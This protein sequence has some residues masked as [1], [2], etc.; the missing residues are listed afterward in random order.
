MN[1]FEQEL[2]KYRFQLQE[3][4]PE[5]F[6]EEGLIEEAKWLGPSIYDAD[7]ALVACSDPKELDRVRL[8]FTAKRFGCE[9]EPEW[10][11]EAIE[12]V[13][14]VQMT[15]VNRKYRAVFQ[16]L[17]AVRLGMYAQTPS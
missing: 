2:D 1:R 4:S 12:H 3:V 14:K 8:A 5:G 16:Y 17:V 11:D 9:Y 15:G 10:I 7:S 13:C 6:N